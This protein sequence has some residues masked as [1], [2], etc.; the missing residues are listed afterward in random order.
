MKLNYLSIFKCRRRKDLVKAPKRF[1]IE[2]QKTHSMKE[3]LASLNAVLDAYI[4]EN[5]TTNQDKESSNSNPT[6]APSESVIAN[7]ILNCQRRQHFLWTKYGLAPKVSFYYPKVSI[8]NHGHLV[9][10][11]KLFSN[12]HIHI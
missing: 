12:W 1:L 3:W 9:S 6:S 11:G 8:S 7:R 5:I 10:D 4:A 2:E